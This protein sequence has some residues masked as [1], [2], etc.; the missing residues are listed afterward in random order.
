MAKLIITNQ[1]KSRTFNPTDADGKKVKA[2]LIALN[3]TKVL[4]TGKGSL[5]LY[6]Q[7]EL[8]VMGYEYLSNSLIK[9][10]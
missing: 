9:I 10:T 8:F 6:H 1:G 5:T 3:I 2:E 7:S 4:A